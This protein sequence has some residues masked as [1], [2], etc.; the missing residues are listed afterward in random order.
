MQLIIVKIKFSLGF[1]MEFLRACVV[2]AATTLRLSAYS[3]V[4]VPPDKEDGEEEDMETDTEHSRQAPRAGD[5]N[6]IQEA[7]HEHAIKM[8]SDDYQQLIDLLMSASPPTT[9]VLR[10]SDLQRILGCCQTGG[11]LRDYVESSEA[12]G[13]DSLSLRECRE[14][15][16]TGKYL[17]SLPWVLHVLRFSTVLVV[18]R[19]CRRAVVL[20][21]AETLTRLVDKDEHGDIVAA[22][23]MCSSA[24]GVVTHVPFFILVVSIMQVA[25]FTYHCALPSCHEAPGHR[26]LCQLPCNS[27]LVFNPHRRREVWRYLT[28]AL[29]HDGFLHLGGNLF[30]QVAFAFPLEVVHSWWPVMLVYVSGLLCGPL[31]QSVLSPNA[32]IVGSSSGVYSLQTAH[33]AHIAA[34][35]NDMELVGLRVATLLLIYLN[36]LYSIIRGPENKH[37]QVL[38]YAGHYGGALAGL[39]VG[40]PVL[41]FSRLKQ[42]YSQRIP[43]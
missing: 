30:F 27:S 24:C 6:D 17:E 8:R 3:W 33:L 4:H 28:Y 16:R 2:I 32:Y 18:G 43:Y 42:C 13:R 31:A 38:S 34:N 25:T 26:Q 1:Y 37:G 41:N 7:P 40:L 20:K 39:V 11:L 12:E 36:D 5:V 22:M 29:V 14:V 9:T 35:F 21:R 15:F 23:N 19:R 10:V